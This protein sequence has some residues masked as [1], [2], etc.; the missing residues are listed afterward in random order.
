MEP[1]YKLITE[2]FKKFLKEGNLYPYGEEDKNYTSGDMLYRFIN[3]NFP[4]VKSNFLNSELEILSELDP[5]E[6]DI[7][8]LTNILNLSI[9]KA[10]TPNKLISLINDRSLGINLNDSEQRNELLR[11]I[12]NLK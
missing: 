5:E 6:Q 4:E 8:Y 1:N 2:N 9:K 7:P 10:N 12:K 3:T 11:S